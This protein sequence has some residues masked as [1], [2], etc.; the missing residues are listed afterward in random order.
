MGNA[1]LIGFNKKNF[2]HFYKKL[3]DLFYAAQVKC[4]VKEISSRSYNF[5]PND[6]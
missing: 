2:D 4:I 5:L 1:N 3:V 6:Y